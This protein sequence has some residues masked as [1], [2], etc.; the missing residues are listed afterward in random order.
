MHTLHLSFDDVNTSFIDLAESKKTLFENVFFAW[1]KKLHEKYNLKVS[2]Y[3]QNWG[4]ILSEIED[5]ALYELKSNS[6]W[7]KL[8][9]HTASDGSDFE[10]KSYVQGKN[11]WEQFV[12]EVIRIGG[13]GSNV[14][15]FPRLH[16][17]VGNEDCLKGM[18]DSKSCGAVGFWLS[19]DDRESYYLSNNSYHLKYSGDFLYDEINR[20]FFKT[21]DFRMDWMRRGFKSQYEYIHPK[22]RNLQKEL[23]RRYE[24]QD[25]IV[26]I[27][28]HEWQVYSKKKLTRYKKWIDY[29][30]IYSLKEHC[31]FVFPMDKIEF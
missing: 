9:I 7:L 13:S 11:E 26:A 28:T 20:L 30:C 3:L 8:G 10:F 29:V 23:K 2:L 17:F 12:N 5:N 22:K 31:E 14:D 16:R 24:K 19:D 27:F 4:D 15:K 21:T 1:L 6:D 25:G 18:R